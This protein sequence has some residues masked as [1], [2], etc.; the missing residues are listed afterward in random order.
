MA[1]R[2]LNAQGEVLGLLPD[3]LR[4]VELRSAAGS[5]TAVIAAGAGWTVP[6]YTVGANQLLIALDGVLCMQGQQYGESGTS[7]EKSTSIIWNIEVDTSRDI[8]VRVR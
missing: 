2:I 5:R 3:S 7:G 8:L 4:A 6:E 1:Y